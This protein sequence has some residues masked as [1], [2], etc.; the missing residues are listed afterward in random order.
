[1]ADVV[2]K[3][4]IHNGKLPALVEVSPSQ[5]VN[6]VTLRNEKD[7]PKSVQEEK[8]KILVPAHEEQVVKKQTDE[9]VEPKR[10]KPKIIIRPPF[11]ERLAQNTKGNETEDMLKFF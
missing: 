4:D 8:D 10:E 3:L 5:H 6:A 11:P 1:M 9:D 7:L 2:Q